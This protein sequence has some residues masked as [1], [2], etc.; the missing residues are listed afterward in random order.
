VVVPIAWEDATMV[1]DIL[2]IPGPNR[3]WVGLNVI[4]GVLNPK[5]AAPVGF[6]LMVA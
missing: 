4:V 6:G 1:N 5:V 3:S 2:T